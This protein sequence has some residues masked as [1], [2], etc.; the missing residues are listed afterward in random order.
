MKYEAQM[1][2]VVIKQNRVERIWFHYFVSY[3]NAYYKI[4]EEKAI[5][6]TKFNYSTTDADIFKYRDI[7]ELRNNPEQRS[8]QLL[9]AGSLKSHTEI[10]CTQSVIN[11]IEQ[12]CLKR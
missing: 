12:S 10:S 6:F 8:S 4:S 11:L 9:H 3:I 5:S 1:K 2:R 7:L